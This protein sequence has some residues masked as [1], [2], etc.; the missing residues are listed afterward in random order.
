MWCSWLLLSVFVLILMMIAFYIKMAHF[1]DP[2]LPLQPDYVG[3]RWFC[4]VNVK[5]FLPRRL[6]SIRGREDSGFLTPSTLADQYD[7]STYQ[8]LLRNNLSTLADKYKSPIY[9]NPAYSVKIIFYCKI[10]I[11]FNFCTEMKENNFFGNLEI[12]ADCLFDFI[13]PY[14]LLAVK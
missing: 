10:F 11:F 14:F 7:C 4:D 5:I 9:I 3:W 1:Q 12:P 6:W 2:I 13:N 8:N